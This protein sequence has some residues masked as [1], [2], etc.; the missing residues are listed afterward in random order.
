M[1]RWMDGQIERRMYLR[2]MY[3][4]PQ[5]PS[6][7]SPRATSSEIRRATASL[8]SPCALVASQSRFSHLA[9]LVASLSSVDEFPRTGIVAWED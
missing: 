6:L 5:R 1:Y 4:N 8:Y 9:L 7:H 2:T 3:P